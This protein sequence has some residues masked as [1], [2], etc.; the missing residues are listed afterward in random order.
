M[1]NMHGFKSGLQSTLPFARPCKT[2][3]TPYHKLQI[4]D[5]SNRGRIVW[6][7]E[8]CILNTMRYKN[9]ILKYLRERLAVSSYIT[10]LQSWAKTVL[11]EVHYFCTF[12]E[13]QLIQNFAFQ[14]ALAQRSKYQVINIKPKRYIH[15]RLTLRMWQRCLNMKNLQ[16]YKGLFPG[17]SL[18]IKKKK[19]INFCLEKKCC[20][21]TRNLFFLCIH[22]RLRARMYTKKLNWIKSHEGYFTVYYA[23]VLNR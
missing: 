9:C 6:F 13:Y 10:I 16:Q 3:H 1:P 17:G 4:V 5:G 8:I 14:T 7:V 12:D 18:K 23:N 2:H 15:T 22:I 21:L 11:G 19:R 20:K